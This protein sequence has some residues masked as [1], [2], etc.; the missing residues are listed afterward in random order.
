MLQT[1]EDVVEN[2]VET[3]V[4]DVGEEELPPIVFKAK[5]TIAVQ[6]HRKVSFFPNARQTPR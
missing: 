6:S 2:I 4:K 5:G 3:V 1:K